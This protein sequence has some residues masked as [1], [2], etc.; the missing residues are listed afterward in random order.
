MRIGLVFLVLPGPAGICIL[1]RTGWAKTGS[2]LTTPA[3]DK[4]HAN[5]ARAFGCI[6]WSDIESGRKAAYQIATVNG[7]KDPF[8]EVLN[9]SGEKRAQNP[10]RRP[11]FAQVVYEP[12]EPRNDGALS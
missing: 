3:G 9:S 7:A 4:F 8:V 11:S 10:S 6:G 2:Y 1:R 12:R 5:G